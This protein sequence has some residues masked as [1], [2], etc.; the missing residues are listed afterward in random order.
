MNLCDELTR[1]P[2]DWGYVAVDG[3]KRP[4]QQSWQDNPLNKDALLAELDSGRARAIGVCCGM[5]S[6]GLLFLDHDGKSA[7]T[8]LPSGD[9]PCH[10]CRGQ[11]AG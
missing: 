4:Y 3:H 11:W 5:P 9:A 6:G 8:L 7:S 2:D 10:R 1:L